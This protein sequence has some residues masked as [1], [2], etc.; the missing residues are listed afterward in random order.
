MNDASCFIGFS[1]IG[2][3]KNLDEVWINF[4]PTLV[5]DPA[6]EQYI[7]PGPILS[8]KSSHSI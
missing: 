1:K 3:A 2:P 8:F 6:S 5:L 7:L 4:D